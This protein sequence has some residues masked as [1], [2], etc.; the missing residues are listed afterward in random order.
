[1]ILDVAN[2]TSLIKVRPVAHLDPPQCIVRVWD[3]LLGI[4]LD[5]SVI[6]S[7][8][9]GCHALRFKE[10]TYRHVCGFWSLGAAMTLQQ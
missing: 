10:A 8:G 6:Q 4:A 7:T 2:Y 9:G 5:V 1:M 3:R